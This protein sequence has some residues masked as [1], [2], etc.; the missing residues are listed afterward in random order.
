M[1]V[2]PQIND[3]SNNDKVFFDRVE[4]TAVKLSVDGSMHLFVVFAMDA[5]QYGKRLNVRA[6]RI[7][8]VVAHAFRLAVIE[9]TDL[10]RS[11]NAS[12]W[13]RIVMH[14]RARVSG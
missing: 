5:R 14:S 9:S 11:L 4:D 1:W 6:Y 7:Q 8:E 2:S 12:S 3:G 10:F 13:I